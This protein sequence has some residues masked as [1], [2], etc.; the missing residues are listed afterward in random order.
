MELVGVLLLGLV[1]GALVGWTLGRSNAVTSASAADP[2]VLEARHQAVV[3]Q[4]RQ[5]E[6]EAR[7]EVSRE[8]AAA[9]ASIAGLQDALEQARREALQRAESDRA[10][11]K[12]L[13]QLAPISENLRAMQKTVVD[14][15]SQRNQQ[16]GVL[17]QEL[18]VTRETAERSKLAA[19]TLASALRN[20]SVRGVYGETQLK[21]LV[22]SA[23]LL[24]RVDFS[25]QESIE[26]ESGARRPD[27][28]INLPGGKQYA[29]DA[30]VPYSAFI[31][32]NRPDISEEH[33]AQHLVQHARQVKGHVDALASK[34]YWSGLA[35]SPEF[36]VAFIP[37]ESILN[38]ALDADPGLMEHAF[39][40]G[41][42]LATPTNLWAILK[43]VAFTW[44]QEVLTE[45]AKNLFDL[46]K[47]LYARL[48]KLAEHAEKLRRSIE[49]TVTSYNSFA[50]SLEQRV[51]VT[52][53]KLD[54]VDETKIIASPRVIDAQTKPLT[55]EEFIA[56][57]DL[58][59]P[60]LDFTVDAEIVDDGRQTG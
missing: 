31:E 10:E 15:E 49:S 44:Q 23:G 2:A 30:K 34:Q 5:E 22:E 47:V 8:L 59:R 36:T 3:A 51:L 14:L 29:V 39:A 17:A 6:A 1:L 57:Q 46:G 56:F 24:R 16:H 41:V 53:R 58:E 33:R 26:A 28:V 21:S 37:N 55:Q 35:A 40:K 4:L 27:M 11:N 60:E 52:A 32:A 42:L 38:A 18:K 7:A 43:T 20:N 25:T 13:Q 45:D 48:S 54:Q 12:V 50:S 9:E 19:E